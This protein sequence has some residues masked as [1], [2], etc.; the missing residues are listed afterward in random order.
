MVLRVGGTEGAPCDVTCAQNAGRLGNPGASRS[1]VCPRAPSRDSM[2]RFSLL[3]ISGPR[4]SSS[5]L[6][7]L[8]GL[9][10]PRA[11]SLPGELRG[12]ADVGL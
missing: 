8:P 9:T 2:E 10:A 4:A 5:A 12:H 1:S 7:A 3:S 6:T 11:T